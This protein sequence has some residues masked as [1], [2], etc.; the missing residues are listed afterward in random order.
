MLADAHNSTHPPVATAPG[1]GQQVAGHVGGV[2]EEPYVSQSLWLGIALA[3]VLV[4]AGSLLVMRIARGGEQSAPA[5]LSADSDEPWTPTELA[6]MGS[7]S[8]VPELPPS[9]TNAVADDERA[10]RLGQT[11]F[12]DQ[13]L[14][15]EGTVS[16]ASCHVPALYFTDGRK[17][18][19]GVDETERHVPTVMGVQWQPF[20]FWDGRAD[21]VWSQ[22]L[23]PLEAEKEHGL[24]RV[25]VARKVYTHH[26][27]AYEALFGPMPSLEDHERFPEDAR[28]VE[29]DSFHLHQQRWAG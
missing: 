5:V 8:P 27:E 21:S 28:P 29:M 11:L 15:S 26:R 14:S 22:A 20:L 18:G 24:T 25:S 4:A 6:L 13:R 12:F 10:A 9:P 16:C 19:F 3:V 7:L 1:D 2:E 17:R 23:G